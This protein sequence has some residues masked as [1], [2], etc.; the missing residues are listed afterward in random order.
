[1]AY[2]FDEQGAG[3]VIAESLA[4]G[5]A[6]FMGHHFPASD[7]PSQARALYVRNIFRVIADVSAAML[8]A[9]GYEPVWKDAFALRG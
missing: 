4:P 3:E 1:M 7:I 9:A 2:R 5:T 8:E 6:S